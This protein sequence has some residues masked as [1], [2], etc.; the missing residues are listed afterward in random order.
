MDASR[1]RA[2]RALEIF[3]LAFESPP[4][5]RAQLLDDQCGDD[6]Q[7]RADVEELLRHHDGSPTIL[8]T[9]QGPLDGDGARELAATFVPGAIGR[10]HITELLGRGGMGVV[11]RA[12]QRDPIRREVALKVVQGGL[13]TADVLARFALERRALAA[14]SHRCIARVFD[15]DSTDDGH[16][17]FVMELVEGPPITAFCDQHELSIPARIRLFQE[18]CRGVQHAHQKGVIHRDLKPSNVLVA[19]GGRRAPSRR[20]STSA[21]AKATDA[22][23]SEQDGLHRSSAC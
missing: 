4:E 8:R 10:Y 15:A 19:P 1:D 11:Y 5:R 13:V 6:P 20:S 12:E 2:A 17:Y 16:P 18:V 14:M 9:D 3:E 21:L 7:L 23:D 22:R